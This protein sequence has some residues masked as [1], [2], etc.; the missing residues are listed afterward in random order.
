MNKSGANNV[1]DFFDDGTSP[2]ASFDAPLKQP[3]SQIGQFRVERQLGRGGAGI[4]YLAQDTKLDRKVAI[5]SLPPELMRNANMRSRLKREAKLLASLDHPNI[6]TIHDI[7]EQAESGGYLI[8]EYIDGHTLAERISRRPLDPKEALSIALQIA[9]AVAAA[10][11]SGVIH[12]DLKPGNIKITP[13][14][15]VKVLDFGLAK[16]IGGEPTDQQSTITEPGRVIGTPAYMSPEQARGQATDKRCDIWSFGCVLYEMLTGKV[17]FEGET[18]SDTLAGILE[19]EPDWRALPP[20]TSV[21]I[22]VLLRRCLEKDPRRRLRDIGDAGIEISE[23]LVGPLSVSAEGGPSQRASWRVVAFCAFVSLVVGAIAMLVVKREPVQPTEPN[24][25]R[26]SIIPLDPAN[27]IATDAARGYTIPRLTPDG[28]QLIYVAGTAA[29]TWLVRRPMDSLDAQ[30][31]PGTQGALSLMPSWDGQWLVFWA[32]GAIWKIPL[33][34]G[35]TVRISN[36]LLGGCVW[37]DENTVILGTKVAGTDGLSRLDLRTGKSEPLTTLDVTP[38]HMVHWPSQFEPDSGTLF[39]MAMSSSNIEDW[40]LFALPPES[41]QSKR[42]MEGAAGSYA[43]SGHL[44]YVQ[45]GRVMAAPFDIKTLQTTGPAVDVTEERMAT[46]ELPTTLTFSRDGTMVYVPVEGGRGLNHE[47]VWVEFDGKEQ[48]LETPPGRYDDLCVSSDTARPQV[49]TD[50]LDGS[51]ILIYD[52]GGAEPIRRLIL[53]SEGYC[54]NPV[55]VP[56]DNR[57]V[58]FYSLAPSG[59]YLLKQKAADGSGEAKVLSVKASGWVGFAPCAYTPDGK[60]LVAMT[61]R[62]GETSTGT[63]IVAIDLERD[64][65]V[66]PL[67]I[68][69]YNE[70]TPALSPDGKWL[71]Y[72]SDELVR[73]EI[74][75]KTFPDMQGKWQVSAE[76]EGGWGPIWAPDGS[77]I[78]YLDGKSVVAV[79]VETEGG[80]KRGHARSLFKDVYVHASGRGY[81]IHPDGKRFL[82]VKKSQE[83]APVTELIVVEN[84]FEEL[85]RRVPTGK[86]K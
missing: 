54:S 82:M 66:K 72:V 62:S 80:F 71:A 43:W 84:W 8:L 56:P 17:P 47:L 23:A 9:E 63:D 68:S 44:I 57:E 69:E 36:S 15:K 7:V 38:G 86:G 64:G 48:A 14:G 11:D 77:A 67:L 79:P 74:F 4:V 65:E 20:A 49:A 52:T 81:D 22:Q 1:E 34:G 83:D 32:G 42:L 78:Y 40:V 29:V 85:K 39:W 6:A 19:R 18:A 10:H 45:R 2:T 51:D 24:P 55:W 41:R 46:D 5:K 26:R 73:D 70:H 27:P 37:E 25:V 12:R 35:K 31:I 28:R 60:V 61:I 76:T 33:A 30:R 59:T 13:E 53:S 3:G 58:V 50:L 75:V 16:A 21:N